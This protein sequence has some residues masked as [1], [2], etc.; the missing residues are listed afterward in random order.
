V[1]PDEISGAVARASALE[2]SGRP[3][4]AVALLAPVPTRYP[5][6]ARLHLAMAS[7]LLDQPLQYQEGLR[8]A[9]RAGQLAPDDP[10]A[11][12]MVALAFLRLVDQKRARVA[13]TRAI[14]LDPLSWHGHYLLAHAHLGERKQHGA[15]VAAARRA[16]ELAPGEPEVYI[17]S[18]RVMV[19][20]RRKVSPQE[21]AVAERFLREALRVDPLNLPARRELASLD[22]AR[23]NHVDAVGGL[24]GVLRSSPLDQ[25]T[26]EGL[27]DAL[28]AMV[29]RTHLVLW[30]A[31]FGL[32][33]LTRDPGAFE[34]VLGFLAS[35]ALAA[36]VGRTL[37]QLRRTLGSQ[38]TAVWRRFRQA[39]PFGMA[40]S[41]ALV[42]VTLSLLLAWFLPVPGPQIAVGGAVVCLAIGALFSWLRGWRARRRLRHRASGPG[43]SS[44]LRWRRDNR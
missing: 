37:W 22:V 13:A 29:M 31:T 7:A 28:V 44:R 33:L 8:H 34:R 27:S 4:D 25:A 14:E 23:K 19:A 36:Y 17:V 42:P 6:E 5:D 11:W 20:G 30:A 43:W 41:L 3:T 2:Q 24:M 10:N 38:S 40:W 18:A 9:Q 35:A 12:R 1:N 39:D 32:R 16:R 26:V 21:F 15:A